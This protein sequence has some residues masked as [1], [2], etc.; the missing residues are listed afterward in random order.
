[1]KKSP[2]FTVIELMIVV[3]VVG[4]LAAIAIPN[5]NE[6]VIRSRI[7]GAVA[8]LSDMNV[9]LEQYFQDNRTYAGACANNTVAPL[10][11]AAANSY[12]T[13]SCPTLNANSYDVLADGQ[14]VM[15]GFKYHVDMNIAVGGV[16]HSGKRTE[17][18]GSGW[19]GAPNNNCWISS[20]SGSC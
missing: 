19:G 9:K 11:P 4:I 8:T 2:G 1:M 18:L 10:P 16:N 17:S 6:Y 13:F 3:A 20:K 12:F 14:G 5:Y 15:A 7:T